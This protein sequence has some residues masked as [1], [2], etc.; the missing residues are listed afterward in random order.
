M[1]R[2]GERRSECAGDWSSVVAR[3]KSRDSG[4]NRFVCCS[5][6]VRSFSLVRNEMLQVLCGSECP[7]GERQAPRCVILVRESENG[8]DV[9]SRG[10]SVRERHKSRCVLPLLRQRYLSVC[11]PQGMR[12]E[13]GVGADRGYGDH[14]CKLGIHEVPEACKT[15]SVSLA[16]RVQARPPAVGGNHGSRATVA[17]Y[18]H[19]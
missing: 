9:R 4:W 11:V 5:D 14:D 12:N 6:C 19:S 7:K 17:Q 13:T 2:H 16:G 3:E 8:K 15:V 1:R 18:T 10:G